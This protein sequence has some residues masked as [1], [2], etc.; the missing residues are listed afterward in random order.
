LRNK[1]G[2]RLVGPDQPMRFKP[3]DLTAA[4]FISL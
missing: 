2:A 4:R 1:F 3:N